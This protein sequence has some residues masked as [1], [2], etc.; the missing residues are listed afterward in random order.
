MLRTALGLLLLVTLLGS[1]CGYNS[2]NY[3]NGPGMPAI[4]QLSP[5]TTAANGPDFVLTVVGTGFGTDSLVYWGTATRGTT[6][7]DTMHVTATI[8]TADIMNVGT[9]QVYVHTGG[10]NSNTMAFTIQ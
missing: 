6:Y 2:R 1:G 5:D 9:V 4:T 10:R 8:T 7:V 3:M